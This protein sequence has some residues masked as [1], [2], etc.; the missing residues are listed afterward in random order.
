MIRRVEDDRGRIL[1]EHIVSGKRVLDKRIAYQVVDMLRGRCRK[2]H[3]RRGCDGS[4][5]IGRQPAKPERQTI[6]TMPGLRDSP[7]TLCTSAWV[8]FDQSRRLKDRRGIG[9]TGGRAAAPIWADFMIKATER[10]PQ[11]DFTV[12][13]DIRFESIDPFTGCKVSRTNKYALK[14]ALRKNQKVCDPQAD[15]ETVNAGGQPMIPGNTP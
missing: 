10:D 2:R 8:G 11:R 9:M 4:D 1:E 6:F 3:R 5:S 15:G 14:V 7:P 12:P 13:D